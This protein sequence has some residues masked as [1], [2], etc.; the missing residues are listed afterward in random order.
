MLFDDHLRIYLAQND[1]NT[2]PYNCSTTGGT[3]LSL[4][5]LI[6]GLV[7]PCSFEEVDKAQSRWQSLGRTLAASPASSWPTRPSSTPTT[8]LSGQRSLLHIKACYADSLGLRLW[9]IDPRWSRIKYKTSPHYL[10]GNVIELLGY[11]DSPGSY[12]DLDPF[13]FQRPRPYNSRLYSNLWAFTWGVWFGQFG[14][15][16]SN[17]W[18]GE[19]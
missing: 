8:S 3:S 12:S 10:Y 5:R 2:I 15:S 18:T 7:G 14:L 4:S 11:W 16:L 19:C 9:V 13:R 1:D 17:P 6:Q